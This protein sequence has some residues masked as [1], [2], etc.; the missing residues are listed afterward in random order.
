M[1][2]DLRDFFLPGVPFD[3]RLVGWR[4]DFDLD[5]DAEAGSSSDFALPQQTNAQT[6][7]DGN[8]NECNFQ[9]R[10]RDRTVETCDTYSIPSWR[11]WTASFAAYRIIFLTC[12]R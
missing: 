8:S 6:S 11:Y 9:Y 12:I 7:E 1:K 10:R 5:L 4:F 2:G 3:C